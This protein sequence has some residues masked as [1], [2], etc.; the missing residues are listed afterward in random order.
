MSTPRKDIYLQPQKC[1]H[2]A[3]GRCISCR[4]D[5]TCTALQETNFI[6][7]SCPFFR[8]RTQMTPRQIAVYEAGC[9][10]GFENVTQSVTDASNLEIRMRAAQADLRP[11]QVADALGMTEAAF[12]KMLRRRLSQEKRERILRAIAQAERRTEP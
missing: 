5:W 6:N 11:W 10:K 2:P 9:E 7:Q 4:R 3:A 8:D 12:G 1:H